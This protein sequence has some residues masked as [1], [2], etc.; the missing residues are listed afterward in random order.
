MRQLMPKFIK[1]IQ[2]MSKNQRWYE[3]RSS[4]WPLPMIYTL[5]AVIAAFAAYGIE[6]GFQPALPLGSFLTV[7]YALTEMIYS[8]LAYGIL[9]I[10]AFTFNMILIVLTSFSGQFTPRVLFSFIADRR[11][12]HAIGVFNLSYFYILISFF[13]LDSSISE[14]V[15]FPVLGVTAASVSA[16]NFILFIN[17]AAK[18][19]QVANLTNNLNER[20]QN[21]ITA[22]NEQDLQ[23]HR[24]YPDKEYSLPQDSPIYSIACSSGGFLQLVDFKRLIAQA[25]KDGLVVYLERRVGDYLLEG[26]TLFSYQRNDEK[27][28]TP[29]NEQTYL[30]FLFIGNKKTEMQDMNFSVR[31]LTE[32]A[33]KA[34]GNNE[35]STAEDAIYQL[36]DLISSISGT[37]SHRPYLVDAKDEA[38]VVMKESTFAYYVYAAFSPIAEAAKKDI[39]I[40]NCVLESLYL[41][42]DSLGGKAPGVCWH[43]AQ[44][45]ARNFEGKMPFDYDQSECFSY[46][47]AVSK[48]AGQ[49]E[50]FNSLME[51]LE[52]GEHISKETATASPVLYTHEQQQEK[53]FSDA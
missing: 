39:K 14:Y 23:E 11:T 43:Y 20:S 10:H 8:T 28:E 51:E 47:R 16:I 38:R 33:L 52:K 3:L 37:A 18:W 53:A 42:A 1:K 32:I 12:L 22:T 24:P 48:A 6:F 34:L 15:I 29:V 45:I 27:P 36:A 25:E 17:H 30:Q 50:A 46:L 31:K 40:T 9:M 21:I 49:R 4:L 2:S 44:S 26:D 35:P 7:D 41:L 19:M 5:I 13:M